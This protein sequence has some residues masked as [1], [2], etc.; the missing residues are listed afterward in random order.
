MVQ[1]INLPLQVDEEDNES[2]DME[3]W[4]SVEIRK[5]I[6]WYV[7]MHHPEAVEQFLAIRKIE[8]ANEAQARLEEYKRWVEREMKIQQKI[9]DSLQQRTEALKNQPPKSIWDRMKE[10]AGYNRKI[11]HGDYY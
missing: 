6:K 11:E 3:K 10:M 8:R 4:G 1:A 7:N 5:F 2:L 9:R